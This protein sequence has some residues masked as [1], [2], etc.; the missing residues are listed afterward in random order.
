MSNSPLIIILALVFIM[1]IVVYALSSKK[2]NT[3][4][5]IR[6]VFK[7][8]RKYRMK[9]SIVHDAIWVTYPYAIFISFLQL[10]FGSFNGTLNIINVFLAI[11]TIIL[12]VLFALFVFYLSKKYS[13]DPEKIPQKY[14][15]IML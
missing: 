4:K 5:H 13:K 12:Y 10:K 9:Y 15:F 8:I 6:K 2:V 3:N 1:Y 14:N 7:K 11:I